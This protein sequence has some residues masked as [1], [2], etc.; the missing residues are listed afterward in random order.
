MKTANRTTGTNAMKLLQYSLSLISLIGL[1]YPAAAQ[2]SVDTLSV[3]RVQL[4]STSVGGKAIFAGGFAVG[5][6]PSSIVDIYDH[7]A[8]TWSVSALT[9]ARGWMSSATVG[10]KAFFAGGRVGVAGLA[11]SRVDIYDDSTGTWS[12]DT[13]SYP[14]Y[15]SAAATLGDKLYIAGGFAAGF[16]SLVDIYDDSTGTWSVQSLSEARGD[17]AAAAVGQKVL[18]AGGWSA[19]GASSVVDIY[20]TSTSTW[21]TAN[22]SAARQRLSAVTVGNKVLFAGG[23]DSSPG[24]S[25]VVDI[26]DDT[27]GTW[28]TAALSTPREF[29]GATAL[30]GGLAMFAGGYDGFVNLGSAMVDLYDSNT[31]AWSTGMIATPRWGLTA[32]NVGG[33]AFFGGG[34]GFVLSSTVDVYASN[35][36]A[37]I[38]YCTGEPGGATPC[39]CG[40]ENDSTLGAGAGC[41]NSTFSSGAQLVDSGL[42]SVSNDSVVF[43]VIG[44]PPGQPGL[45]FQGDNALN[46]G[47]GVFFGDGLRC[48]GGSLVRLQVVTADGAGSASSTPGIAATAGVSSGDVKRYQY[49]YRD[50]V[51]GHCGYNFNTSNGLE[52]VWFN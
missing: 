32:T 28:S 14:R 5:G 6:S 15:G 4:A 9:E 37:G 18:F 3:P 21:S 50:P 7:V 26:F 47:S 33:T 29:M 20:D 22:L 48:A 12:Q 2:W 25:F 10:S 42:P 1:S 36:G 17:L 45:F 38:V 51:G 11:T 43:T 8:G 40:N 13:L 39:P 23:G 34:S 49:W 41:Q 52:V 27:T 19:S 31:G 24:N 35:Y 30:G 46:G 16:L 44:L